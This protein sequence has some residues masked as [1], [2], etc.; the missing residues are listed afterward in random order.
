LVATGLVGGSVDLDLARICART[1]AVN[2][3]DAALAELGTLAPVRGV[4]RLRVYVAS[5]PRF[6]DQHL[7][8]DAATDL[9][10][11]VLGATLHTRTALGVAALP[12]GS[13]VE[14]DADLLLDA[15]WAAARG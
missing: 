3:L 12:L 4:A 1:C 7:V 6:T 15:T 2:V 8:A 11:E 10:R 5:E 13:P 14:V 9:F